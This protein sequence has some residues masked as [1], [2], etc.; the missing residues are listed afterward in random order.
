MNIREPQET[1]SETY[2]QLEFRFV[3]ARRIYTKKALIEE[4][5]THVIDTS[6]E[7]LYILKYNY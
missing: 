2:D 6:I 1:N 7:E 3:N 4:A 5:N